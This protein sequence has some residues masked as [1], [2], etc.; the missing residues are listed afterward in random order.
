MPIRTHTDEEIA[1]I[2]RETGQIFSHWER[3]GG[4]FM[5]RWCSSYD[6]KTGSPIYTETPTTAGMIVEVPVFKRKRVS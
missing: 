1:R 4:P 2:E 3:V 5:D 6:K